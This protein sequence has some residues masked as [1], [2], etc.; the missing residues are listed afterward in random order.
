MVLLGAYFLPPPPPPPPAPLIRNLLAIHK[1]MDY[2]YVHTLQQNSAYQLISAVVCNLQQRHYF[3]ETW[4]FHFAIF[5]KKYRVL[6]P[7][8]CGR[9]EAMGGDHQLALVGTCTSTIAHE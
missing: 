4:V 2:L 6:P 5:E 7:S 9:V 8:W 3:C 1:V